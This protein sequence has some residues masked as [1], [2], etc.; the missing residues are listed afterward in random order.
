MPGQTGLTSGLFAE[1]VAATTSLPAGVINIFTESGNTGSP[2]L[3]DSADVDVISYTGSTK[4]GR[5]IAAAGAKTLKRMNLE[6]GGKTPMIVFE[7]ADLDAVAPLLAQALTTFSGQ[8]CMAG[9]RILAARS[10][11]DDL[12]AK[13]V[14]LIENVRV[15][16]SDDPSSQMGP[17]IDKAA[18]ERIDRRSEEHTSELQSLMRISYAVFCLK[19]QK[20]KTNQNRE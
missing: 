14:K 11:A 16:P 9:T 12:R 13:L 1:A 17:V 15:G 18:V 8:F 5:I 10:I 2:A 4:V 6:L 20:P 7:D 3:V 19:K